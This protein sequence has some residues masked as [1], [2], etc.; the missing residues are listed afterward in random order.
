MPPDVVWLDADVTRMA[1]VLANLLNNAAKYTPDRGTIALTAERQ[2]GE[3]V[4]RVRDNGIG[5]SPDLLPRVFDMFT[6]LATDERSRTGLGLGLTIVR[7]LVEMHGGRVGV[8]SEGS[9][10]GS[11]FTVRLPVAADQPP[12]PASSAE[13]RAS[14][15]RLA[16]QRVLVVDD[17]RDAAQ[18]LGDLLQLAGSVVR[19]VHDARAA[20][21]EAERFQPTLALLDIGM[22][23]MNGYELARRLRGM[24]ALQRLILVAVTG[25][26]Q[27]EDR[28]RSRE[29]GFNYHLTKPTDLASLDRLLGSATATA[30]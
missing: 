7:R 22:P 25:W 17:N 27:D 26:G 30:R 24:P 8:T 5:I 18:S 10:R 16:G 15:S 3:V 20:L 6:Q 2:A 4:V 1:Q 12:L 29:A 9:G 28:R 11:E 13:D 21:D 19:V 14:M 23:G